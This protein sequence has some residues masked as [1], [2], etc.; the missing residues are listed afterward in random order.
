MRRARRPALTE[1]ERLVLHG[2]GIEHFNAG[3]FLE[4]HDAW[5]RIWRSP[6]PDPADLFQG[7]IQVAVALHHHR[8]RGRPDVCRRVL[9]RARRRLAGRPGRELG[10]DLDR[11]RAD[12][13][14]WESWLSGSGAGAPPPPPALRRA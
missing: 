13:D 4:A 3:R 9:A 6:D 5:E 11:L 12:L 2:A 14:R 7:L 1:A 10:L 8:D